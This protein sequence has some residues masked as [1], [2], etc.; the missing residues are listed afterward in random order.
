MTVT[1]HSPTPHAVH[2]SL[3]D[4]I[5]LLDRAAA[6]PQNRRAALDAVRATSHALVHRDDG[7][8]DEIQR[9]EPRLGAQITQLSDRARALT[10]E[11]HAVVRMLTDDDI[12]DPAAVR[13]VIVELARGVRR[14]QME[15][16]NIIFEALHTDLGAGD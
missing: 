1:D 2:P 12:A 4:A 11:A 10:A 5:A 3:R 6:E 13:E 15:E 16:S 8:L 14:H 7:L 9:G